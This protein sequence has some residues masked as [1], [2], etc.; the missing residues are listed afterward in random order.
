MILVPCMGMLIL[1]LAAMLRTTRSPLERA[2]TLTRREA[3]RGSAGK[4]SAGTQVPRRSHSASPFMGCGLPLRGAGRGG[5]REAA[6]MRAALELDPGDAGLLLAT[7]DGGPKSDAGDLDHALQHYGVGKADAAPGAG[8]DKEMLG[9]ARAVRASGEG[10]PGSG[11]ARR[12]TRSGLG[13]PVAL[14][15][16]ALHLLR[17]GNPDTGPAA[18]LLNLPQSLVGVANYA[19]GT[20]ETGLAS[21][22]QGDELDPALA[23]PAE[24]YLDPGVALESPTP[25]I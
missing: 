23:K 22:R 1:L 5:G 25:P 15:D 3:V 12:P 10:G 20:V 2:V 6:E 9:E 18:R 16:S 21:H 4:R 24:H 19:A 11:R 17:G 13:S 7:G 8:A 14:A